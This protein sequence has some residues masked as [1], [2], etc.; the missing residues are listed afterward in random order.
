MGTSAT[1]VV[2][3]ELPHYASRMH[4]PVM[5][6]VQPMLAKSVKGDPRPGQVGG[7]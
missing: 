7:L 1:L 5:P 2:A 3:T 4:L 6:P